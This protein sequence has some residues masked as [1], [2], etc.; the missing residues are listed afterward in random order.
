MLSAACDCLD[1]KGTP[2]DSS[3]S[4][5]SKNLSVRPDKKVAKKPK[6]EKARADRL[7]D[8]KGGPGKGSDNLHSFKYFTHSVPCS[9][10]VRSTSNDVVVSILDIL[11][12]ICTVQVP[13]VLGKQRKNMHI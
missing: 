3:V 10:M 9:R 1:G 12:H 4:S 6:V 13:L 11:T 5:C 8:K 7:S 2:S